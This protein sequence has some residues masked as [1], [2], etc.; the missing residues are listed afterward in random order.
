MS[1]WNNMG[2]KTKVKLPSNVDR[3]EFHTKIEIRFETKFEIIQ[4]EGGVET[5]RCLSGKVE[6]SGS[7]ICIYGYVKPDDKYRSLL[8]ILKEGDGIKPIYP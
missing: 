2:Y 1:F 4:C 5:F 7:R 3:N 8:L 6:V